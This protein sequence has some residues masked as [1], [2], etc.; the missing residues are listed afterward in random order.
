MINHIHKII[1][2]HPPKTGGWSIINIFGGSSTV[3]GQDW[4]NEGMPYHHTMQFYSNTGF[5]TDH[6]FTFATTRNPWKRVVS[7]YYWLKNFG[8][9]RMPMY[10]GI[11]PYKPYSFQDYVKWL[12]ED[13]IGVSHYRDNSF[14]SHPSEVMDFTCIDGVV[15]VDYFCDIETYDKD[16]QFVTDIIQRNPHLPHSNKTNHDEFKSY[17]DDRS[18]EIVAKVFKRDIDYFKYSFENLDGSEYDRV[19]NQNKIDDYKR[20]RSLLIHG[21]KRL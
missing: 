13:R 3:P 6:Y 15:A 21:C 18:V 19:V 1:Y 8:G 17:Y 5:N 2:I 9:F 16:F 7:A 14:W 11:K 20:S 4:G 10:K 12:A